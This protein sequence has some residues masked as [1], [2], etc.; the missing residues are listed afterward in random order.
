VNALKTISDLAER[1]KD[2]ERDV[3]KEGKL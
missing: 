1:L 2:A 3:A